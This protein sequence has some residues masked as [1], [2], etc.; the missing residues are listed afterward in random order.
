MK[1]NSRS[2]SRRNVGLYR[3]LKPGALARLRDS[4]VNARSQKNNSMLAN[5][6]THQ[7][8]SVLTQHPPQTQISAVDR[9]PRLLDKIYGGPCCLRRK[10]LVAAKSVYLLNLNPSEVD[11]E[12][13]VN[14]NGNNS[15]GGDL[16]IS[17]LNSDVIVAR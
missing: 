3:Y 15:V 4:K 9:L 10:K 7:V 1:G 14:N 13:T 12:S 2:S 11:L 6:L 17:V 16:L 8:D 5:L